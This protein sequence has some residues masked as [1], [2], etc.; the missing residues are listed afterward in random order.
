MTG[1]LLALVTGYGVAALA[2]TTFLSCLAMPV[3]ASLAMLAAGGFA[4]AGDLDWRV[5]TAAALLGA[6]AGDQ[7]GYWIGRGIGARRLDRLGARSARVRRV[8]ADLGRRGLVLVFLSRWL[9]SPLGPYVN[10][11]AGAARLPWARFTLGE[12]AGEALWVAI[13]VG[14][15]ALFAG[16]IEALAGILGNLSGLLAA[17][18][19]AGAALLWLVRSGRART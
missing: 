18:A 17:L 10:F 16:Q 6:V 4:A 12:V 19:V 11:A 7:T 1:T 15:G 13:Y 3:P 8:A 2:L 14:L 5:V 9:L